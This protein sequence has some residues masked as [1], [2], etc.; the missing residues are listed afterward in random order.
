MYSYDSYGWFSAQEIPGRT[1][2]VEPPT[3]G[4]KVVGEL[5][6]NYTGIEWVMVAYSDPVIPAPPPPPRQSILT[7]LEYLRRFT[8]D[9]RVAIRNA[10]KVNAV[11]EDYMALLDLAQE[12]NL[13]DPDTI[14]GVQMLEAA[15]LL[16][17][18]RAQ[19]ILA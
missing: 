19:E 14:A 15:G 11:L 2:T 9:E 1:T 17:A 16:N 4:D 3:H 10:A 18:G 7:K 5:Y 12:I 8:Q 6:P 13:D